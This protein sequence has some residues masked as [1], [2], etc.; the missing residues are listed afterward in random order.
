MINCVYDQTEK[1]LFKW[2]EQLSPVASVEIL[3]LDVENKVAVVE[4]PEGLLDLL[5]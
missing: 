4:I 5:D 1:I 2:G 3:G